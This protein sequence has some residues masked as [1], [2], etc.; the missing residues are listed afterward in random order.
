[1]VKQKK[2]FGRIYGVFLKSRIS[3]NFSNHV[4]FHIK[5][6]D[7]RSFLYFL[8]PT[9]ELNKFNIKPQGKSKRVVNMM[10]SVNTFE[11]ELQMMPSRPLASRNTTL[12]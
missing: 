2:I 10:S 6:E 1:M 5:S 4:D 8:F 9:G 11:S 3:L 12:R 7:Q